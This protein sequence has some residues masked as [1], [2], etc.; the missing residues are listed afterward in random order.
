VIQVPAVTLQCDVSTGSSRCRAQVTVLLEIDG[1]IRDVGR[2]NKDGTA[3]ER[4]PADW[5]ELAEWIMGDGRVVDG[6]RY[7]VG[8]CRRHG[9]VGAT[10]DDVLRSLRTGQKTVL[11][12]PIERSVG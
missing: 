1:E 3:V 10:E 12:R 4:R 9:L 6:V 11:A 2:R 8:R 7:R 5:R